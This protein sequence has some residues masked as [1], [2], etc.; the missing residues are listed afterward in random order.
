MTSLLEASP[1]LIA[2]TL[3]R[4]YAGKD[5]HFA[6]VLEDKEHWEF[7]AGVDGL[8]KAEGFNAQQIASQYELGIGWDS[9]TSDFMPPMV[10]ND[11]SFCAVGRHAQ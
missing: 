6:G 9:Q 3:K 8:G 7:F 10:Q 11:K 2:N 1:S 5:C 4:L